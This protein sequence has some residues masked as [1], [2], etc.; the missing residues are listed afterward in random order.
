MIIIGDFFFF[1]FKK[2][3][4]L[5]ILR[6]YFKYFIN[7]NYFSPP[8]NSEISTIIIIIS[9]L[10]MRIMNHRGLNNLPTLIGRK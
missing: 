9:I 5:S 4:V 10:H 6:D 3:I 2:Q 7:V 1:Y 8:K